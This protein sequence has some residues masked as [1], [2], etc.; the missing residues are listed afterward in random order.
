MLRE[1]KLNLD[2]FWRSYHSTVEEKRQFLGEKSTIGTMA[3]FTTH[4]ARGVHHFLI[5]TSV[6]GIDKYLK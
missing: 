1:C 4:M 3:I 2:V 5:F 6:W